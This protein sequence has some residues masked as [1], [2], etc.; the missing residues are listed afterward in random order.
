MKKLIFLL[1]F[2]SSLLFSFELKHQNKNYSINQEQL[3]TYLQIELKTVR[4]KNGET[5]VDHWKG[6]SL[7]YL[8]EK[9]EINDFEQL[10][11]QSEDGYLIRLE[12]S[13]ISAKTMIALWQNGKP[14]PEKKM[15]LVVPEMR[16]MFWIQ[17]IATLQTETA[18]Q[19]E[20]PTIF[21]S[22]TAILQSLQL[23]QNP[24]PFTNCEGYHLIELFGDFF[25]S[26]SGDFYLEGKDGVNHTLDFE[27]YLKK[28]VLIKEKSGL[29][30]K[31][32][33]MPAGMWIKN[34]AFLQ[35]D[36]RILYFQ[37]EFEN[38][39]DFLKTMNLEKQ[40]KKA[41]AFTL[42]GEKKQLE[43]NEVINWKNILKIQ[44]IY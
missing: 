15:R 13:D 40:P 1:L 43:A 23:K 35:S 30:L 10:V 18:W 33:A 17:E 12:K 29:D 9:Y 5:K 38:V 19:P 44:L 4:D 20:L 36:E 32:P 3:L 7:T 6:V 42:S 28:A 21:Y 41:I 8:L 31:S 22:A 37:T 24:A 16:D 34:I 14:L 2:S 39:A 25:P 27:T 26:L 11:A